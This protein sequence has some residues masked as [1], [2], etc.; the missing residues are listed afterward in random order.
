MPRE[1]FA[2]RRRCRY[3]T[4]GK[5]QILKLRDDYLKATGK[6]LQEFHNAFVSQGGM[7]VKLVR[8]VLLPDTA[9]SLD[10]RR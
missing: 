4:L 2:R 10:L 3:Y 5:L 9:S 8:R 1:T 6:S 7:P